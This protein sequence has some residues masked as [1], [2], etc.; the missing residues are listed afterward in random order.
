MQSLGPSFDRVGAQT[1]SS[2]L[3]L[4]MV[5]A[6]CRSNSKRKTKMM[7]DCGTDSIPFRSPS[8]SPLKL[9]ICVGLLLVAVKSL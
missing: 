5:F 6:S 4:V 7:N 3:G 9:V 2:G 1:C 8:D